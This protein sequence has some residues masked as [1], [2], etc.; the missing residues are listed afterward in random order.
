MKT[1]LKLETLNAIESPRYFLFFA[2]GFLLLLCH[3]HAAIEVIG[4]QYQ[5]D[6]PYPEYQC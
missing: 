3:A 2:L 5:Q 4:V 1:K 6:N